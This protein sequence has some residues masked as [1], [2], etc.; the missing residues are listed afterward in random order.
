MT[1]TVVDVA[2]QALPREGHLLGFASNHINV[3]PERMVPADPTFLLTPPYIKGFWCRVMPEP[4][5]CWLW[6]GPRLPSGYGGFTWREGGRV[7]G[8]PAIRAAYRIAVGPIPKGHQLDHLCHTADEACTGGPTCPHRPCVNPSHLEPVTPLENAR[9]SRP[10]PSW[11]AA[12]THCAQGHPFD[13]ENTFVPPRGRYKRVCR[14]CR[15]ENL[16]R[17]RAR[18]AA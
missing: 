18:Q 17:F 8:T 7:R 11:Q 16:R 5:G 9:R 10:A 12:K 3:V 4:T 14:T 6:Q 2:H 1:P 15:R 13:E